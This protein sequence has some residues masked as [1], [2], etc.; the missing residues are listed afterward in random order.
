[1]KEKY[2]IQSGTILIQR[3]RVEDKLGEGGM[4]LVY[5]AHDTLLDRPVAIKMLSPHF[6]GAEGLKRLLREAQSAAKLTHPNIVAVYD[7]LEDSDSRLIVMECVAG[8][9]LRE[10]IPLKWPQ[11]VAIASQVSL[12]L[13][14]A[15]GHGVVHRDIKPENIM[16]TD[17]EIVKVMDFGLAR[18]EGRSRLTQ[19]G[20]IVGT[21][22]YMAPEQVLGGTIDARTDLYS[23]GCVIYESLTARKPF[24]G[25]DPFMVL[26]QHMNV[27]PVAPRWHNG[28]IPPTLDA[29]I[30]RLLAKDP[31]ERYASAI[32]VLEALKLVAGDA[33]P[34]P[35]AE[36]EAPATRTSVLERIVRGRLVGRTEELREL[37]EHLDRMLSAEGRLVLISGEPGIGKTR[38]AEELAVYAHLRGAWVLRGHCYEQDV[39]VPYLPF[40]ETLRMLFHL[41]GPSLISELGDRADDLARFLPELSPKKSEVSVLT[42]EDERI[43]VFEAAARWVSAAAHVRPVVFVL[44]DLQWADRASLRLLHH[45]GRSTRGERVLVLGTYREMDLDVEH[46]LNEILRQMNRERL[47]YRLHVRRLSEADTR[48]LLSGLLDEMVAPDL[49][50]AVHHETEGNPFFIEEVVKALVEEGVIYR[51]GGRWQRLKIEKL[52]IPQSVKAVVGQRVL[53]A[54]EICHRV[55]TI[56]AIIGREFDPDLLVKI[57]QLEEDAVLDALDEAIRLQLIREARLDRGAGYVFEHA[58]IRQ[59][60]Y[61]SLNVR[62]RA[63]LHQQVGEALEAQY[64]TRRDDRIEELAYHFGEAGPT[65]APK[66]IEY[67]L[68]AA[69]KA[70]SLY[71]MEEAER[72]LGVALELSES[73]G[74]P[75]ARANVLRAQGDLYSLFVDNRRAFDA[76]QRALDM[77]Q[78]QDVAASADE[79]LHLY[80]KIA[81]VS[82]VF[83]TEAPPGAITYAQTAVDRLRDGP[84]RPL[85]AR[86]LSLLAIHHA[87]AGD[88]PSA[89]AHAEQAVDLATRLRDQDELAIAYRATAYMHR[90][91]NEW[92]QFHEAVQ[93]RFAL[94]GSVLAAADVEL[95]TDLVMAYAHARKMAEAEQVA[96]EFLAVAEKLRSPRAI[97]N[98]CTTLAEILF[99]R[100]KWDEALRSADRAIGIGGY[101]LLG[102]SPLQLS[103]LILAARGEDDIARQRI[104]TLEASSYEI[105]PEHFGPRQQALTI[106]VW[107]GDQELVRG[108]LT[109]LEPE[110]P[111]CRTCS[112][113]FHAHGAQG[114]LLLGDVLGAETAL[115][116]AVQYLPEKPRLDQLSFLADLR[117]R[118][119]EAKGDLDEAARILDEIPRASPESPLTVYNALRQENA[120]RIY[121]ARRKP[122]DAERATQ[123]LAAAIDL[124]KIIGARRFDDRAKKLL[125]SAR[126][127]T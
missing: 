30:M 68:R 112:L 76:Y 65:T 42:P 72:R 51:E 66:G 83:G 110:K 9:T 20:L 24:E 49:A 78:G 114:R 3:Y 47:F 60:L 108:I 45:L 29:I 50:G 73:T 86:A 35:A 46:P 93:K 77:L 7:V 19:S 40:M 61:E 58:L 43:R 113:L 41:T 1:M 109:R 95:Y 25:D 96:R 11:A 97:S 115:G 87:R 88:L 12:A 4:G 63:R 118:I 126:N 14:Y 75:V 125:D 100:N 10:L 107:L 89:R 120:G 105:P 98:A 28:D 99:D 48:V 80:C 33:A 84:D 32:A 31:N 53:K 27:M 106:A 102:S 59:T 56:A 70:M 37:R 34:T 36:L 8:R 13:E 16:V 79:V 74:D 57:S 122:D 5:K 71:A 123:F 111:R 116:S 55:L 117:A 82:A 52:E 103:G 62:R 92:D 54:G 124:Y 17:E 69:R 18:S 64:G 6:L 22:A 119:A 21:V 39:G 90:S 23:L 67:N 127:A 94:R 26:S 2:V 104:A 101:H 91:N 121:L 44:E 15:H 85:K 38:L 81:E